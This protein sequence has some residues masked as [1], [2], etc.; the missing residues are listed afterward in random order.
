MT[1][2]VKIPKMRDVFTD[3][4]GLHNFNVELNGSHDEVL[5]FMRS[6]RLHNDLLYISFPVPYGEDSGIVQISGHCNDV[7]N[8]LHWLTDQY[9]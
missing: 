1:L 8:I 3:D 6:I 4:Y 2:T 9:S 5:M 7:N